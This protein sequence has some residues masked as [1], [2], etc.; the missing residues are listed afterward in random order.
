MAEALT[1]QDDVPWGFIIG[2]GTQPGF[3]S[4]IQDSGTPYFQELADC[5]KTM[6]D[7][8]SWQDVLEEVGKRVAKKSFPYNKVYAKQDPALYI[9]CSERISLR[10]KGKTLKP[11]KNSNFRL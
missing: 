5:M 9:N 7:N 11:C 6:P 8:C 2:F 1:I 10:D 4:Y 3:L